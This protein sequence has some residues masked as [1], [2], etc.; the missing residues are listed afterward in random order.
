MKKAF[1]WLNKN[2][3]VYTFHNYK[4][5]GISAD[6]IKEWLKYKPITEIINTKSTTFKNL[7]E[8]DQKKIS[9]SR[10]AIKL[11]QENTSMIKRPVLETKKGILLGFNESV[12]EKELR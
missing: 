6:K 10:A 8:S 1:D 2:N 4:D 9:N 12:W 11:I 3:K 7:P 5:Q